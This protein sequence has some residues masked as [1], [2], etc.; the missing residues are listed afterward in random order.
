M[1]SLKRAL[2]ATEKALIASC[3]LILIVPVIFDVM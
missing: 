2:D 1:R 3:V